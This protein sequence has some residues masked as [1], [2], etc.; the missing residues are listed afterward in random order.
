MKPNKLYLPKKFYDEFMGAKFTID[1]PIYHDSFNECNVEFV[2][3]SSIWHK[4]DET[5]KLYP[6]DI[7]TRCDYGK[8][9][10]FTYSIEV[11]RYDNEK[12]Y[13]EDFCVC[14]NAIA[15]CYVTDIL[16]KGGVR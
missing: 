7:I 9:E 13:N 15:W 4:P 10:D 12:S 1:A 11:H 3:I 16:P 5:P 8:P 14:T 6:C 2:E